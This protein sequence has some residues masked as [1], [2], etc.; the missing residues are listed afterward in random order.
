MLKVNNISTKKNKKDFLLNG[1]S[2]ELKK[3]SFHI[4][5]GLN[6][7]GKTTLLQCM[8]GLRK[9][10]QGEVTIDGNK[11]DSIH[12]KSLLG[13]IP[14]DI[15]FSRSQT[16]KKFLEYFKS[17]YKLEIDNTKQI[18]NELNLIN[19]LDK[20]VTSLSSG[21]RKK[22]LIAQALIHNPKYLVLDEP[23]AN[24]EATTRDNILIFLKSFVD[25]GGS[26]FVASHNLWDLKDYAHHISIVSKGTIIY[27]QDITD[28]ESLVE[29]FKQKVKHE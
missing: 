23:L 7:S 26:V 21:E 15:T 11:I 8:V 6:G 27:D 1:I 4:L 2:L 19:I 25:N 17:F 28:K 20:K 12:A 5:T 22:V 16:V 24:L 10:E 29:I 18:I 13:Y 3:G 14:T 9:I